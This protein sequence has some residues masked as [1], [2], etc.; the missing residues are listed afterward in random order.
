[1]AFV[2]LTMANPLSTLLGWSYGVTVSKNCRNDVG[3]TLCVRGTTAANQERE[4]VSPTLLRGPF[5]R[6]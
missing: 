1:M 3:I 5:D 2:N 6:K 4:Y